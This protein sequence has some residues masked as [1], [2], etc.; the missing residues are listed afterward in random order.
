MRSQSL[1]SEI[2][3]CSEFLI[4]LGEMPQHYPLDWELNS[5]LQ[6]ILEF[7]VFSLYKWKCVMEWE[8]LSYISVSLMEWYLLF[9]KMWGYVSS[10]IPNLEALAEIWD[11]EYLIQHSIANNSNSIANNSN[12]WRRTWQPPPVLLPR[13]FHG[14]RSLVGYSVWC[15]KESDTTEQLSTHA[16]LLLWDFL[17]KNIGMG[18]HLLLQGIFLTQGS[19]PHPISHISWI[20]RWILYHWAT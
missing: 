18:C 16:I 1:L 9:F 2:S 10:S 7:L 5:L 11:S 4:C 12:N 3:Q 19:N 15:H 17:G 20:G 13:E 14:Q 6:R 8:P